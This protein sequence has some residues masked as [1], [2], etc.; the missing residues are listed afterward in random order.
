M[1]GGESSTGSF[2]FGERTKINSENF[3]IWELNTRSN[4]LSEIRFL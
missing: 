2:A 4:L 1:P 3:A